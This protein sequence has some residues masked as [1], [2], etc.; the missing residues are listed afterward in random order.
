MLIILFLKKNELL[1]NYRKIVKF[2]HMNA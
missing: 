1:G 2:L